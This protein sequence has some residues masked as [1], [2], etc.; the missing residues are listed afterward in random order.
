MIGQ[1]ITWILCAIIVGVVLYTIQPK[2]WRITLPQESFS[3][4]RRG[5]FVRDYGPGDLAH[6]FPGIEHYV[7]WKTGQETLLSTDY[8]DIVPSQLT[9][10]RTAVDAE[11]RSF[12]LHP[13]FQITR[14]YTPDSARRIELHLLDRD[15]DEETVKILFALQ[16]SILSKYTIADF[17]RSNAYERFQAHMRQAIN[18]VPEF[19]N[20]GVIIDEFRFVSIPLPKELEEA[21][22]IITRAKAE[23][24]AIGLK[25][26]AEVQAYIKERTAQGDDWA[27]HQ[28]LDTLPQLAQLRFL[29]LGRGNRMA[30]SLNHALQ[31]RE[32]DADDEGDQ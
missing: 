13:V 1:L 22:G 20:W 8:E 31:A 4:K 12:E 7:L 2:A 26:E 17:L 14:R 30:D 24:E 21:A 29:Q 9:K 23:A 32:L 10:V 28:W 6:Y 18:R 19:K 5:E 3:V 16:N 11:G 15:P 27:L 25:S